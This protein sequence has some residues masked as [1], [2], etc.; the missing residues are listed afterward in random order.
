MDPPSTRPAAPISSLPVQILLIPDNRVPSCRHSTRGDN[1]SGGPDL[2]CQESGNDPE[3]PTHATPWTLRGRRSWGPMAGAKDAEVEGTCHGSG[4]TFSGF[5]G[6][7][8]R[9][10]LDPT[11]LGPLAWRPS[12]LERQHYVPPASSAAADP[13]GGYARVPRS[14]ATAA[15]GKDGMYSSCFS[16]HSRTRSSAMAACSSSSPRPGST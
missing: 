7:C 16:R 3:C 1:L 2:D 8:R 6:A 15:F 11:T 9:R 4:L 10:R 12:P 14:P 5:S 13:S